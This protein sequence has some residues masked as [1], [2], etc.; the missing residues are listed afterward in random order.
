MIF[1]RYLKLIFIAIFFACNVYAENTKVIGLGSIE[2]YLPYPGRLRAEKTL[3][4]FHTNIRGLGIARFTFDLEKQKFSSPKYIDKNGNEKIAEMN[5]T[6][7]EGF[8]K[9]K[10]R[11]EIPVHATIKPKTIKVEFNTTSPR[12]LKF[13]HYNVFVNK[14]K[15]ATV[16]RKTITEGFFG[17]CGMLG[18][19]KA[20]S[21]ADSKNRSHKRIKKQATSSNSIKVLDIAVEGDKDW[22][23]DF[24]DDSLSE[25]TSVVSAADTIYKD[26]LGLSFNIVRQVV[27]TDTN[28]GGRDE[29]NQVDGVTMLIDYQT[30]TLTKSYFSEADAF[31][32]FSSA[33]VEDGVVGLAYV[34]VIC[35]NKSNSFAFTARSGITGT[36]NITFAHEM[37]HNFNAEHTA[38][39][40]MQGF[41]SFPL[42]TS[43]SSE[44]VEA[45]TAFAEENSSCLEDGGNDDD[46]GEED[47]DNSDDDGG[48]S[49][50]G[51]GGNGGETG[52]IEIELS[53][54]VGAFSENKIEINLDNTYTSTTCDFKV[55]ASTTRSKVT[56][57]GTIIY[58]LEDIG[59]LGDFSLDVSYSELPRL[60]NRRTGKLNRLYLLTQVICENG[61]KG[62]SKIVRIKPDYTISSGE[63]LRPKRWLRRLGRDFRISSN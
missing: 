19:S 52:H 5:L 3:L 37:G 8:L 35:A 40:I 61:L 51:G 9:I 27:Y 34:G 58:L 16:R 36:E 14:N 38:S 60:R 43:F 32:L 48:S 6:L 55:R 47:D 62:E 49:P 54:S 26:E 45:I 22:F 30:Q 1:R 7:L 24:G 50:P 41:L 63:R 23:D 59:N 13:R 11:H 57:E 29:N 44:S 21:H 15:K 4:K 20:H 10:N 25:I 46:D 56:H 17:A 33:D 18:Q 12:D 2:K 42:P 39:G 31:H 53:A 28:F